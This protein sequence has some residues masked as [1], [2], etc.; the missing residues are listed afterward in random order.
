MI[1]D[2]G[3]SPSDASQVSAI[4]SLVGVVSSVVLGALAN[5][6]G[7]VRVASGTMI[8]FGL[9]IAVFGITP[10]V[11]PML[12]LAACASGF[13]LSA[14]TA[15]FYSTLAVSFPPNIRVSGIGFVI[16]IGRVSSVLGPAI[17]GWMFA[18][19]L[20]REEV[21]LVFAVVPVIAGLILA[22]SR[23]AAAQGQ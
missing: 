5:R 14:T 9:A 23:P 19:G 18:A 3:F 11:L 12:T 1:A 20:A 7:P 6:L 8:G 2:A 22:T 13:C 21:L 17:G 15:V 10:P 4:A 16:G